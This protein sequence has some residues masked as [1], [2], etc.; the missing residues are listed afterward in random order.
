[1]K[2]RLTSMGTPLPASASLTEAA[3]FTALLSPLPPQ[4][5][6]KLKKKKNLLCCVSLRFKHPGGWELVSALGIS[7]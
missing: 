1:M 6:L 2:V 5:H 7:S 3:A 4:L